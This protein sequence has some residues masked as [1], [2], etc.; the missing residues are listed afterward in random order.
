MQ[1]PTERNPRT[2]DNEQPSDQQPYHTPTLI[3]YGELAELVQGNPGVG[4][5]ISIFADC[6]RS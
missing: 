6:T 4:P 3:C 5:D 1:E 2:D